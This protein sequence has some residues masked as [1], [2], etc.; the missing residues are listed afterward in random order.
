[1]QAAEVS[2]KLKALLTI[3]GKVQQDGRRVTTEDFQR[4]LR[5]GAT[6]IKI[7]DTVLIAAA[8]CMYNRCVDGL[9]TVQP[10]DPDLYRQCGKIVALDGYVAANLQ[11]VLTLSAAEPARPQR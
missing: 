4:A 6:D 9:A 7:Y 1:M 5:K 10:Q 8:S 2:P 3:A 11:N